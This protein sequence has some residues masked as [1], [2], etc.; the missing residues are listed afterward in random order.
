MSPEINEMIA[1][2]MKLQNPMPEAIK[3]MRE[4]AKSSR[5]MRDKWNPIYSTSMRDPRNAVAVLQRKRL[6]Y[7]TTRNQ[8]AGD[9]LLAQVDWATSHLLPTVAEQ[10]QVLNRLSDLYGLNELFTGKAF[11]HAA[12]KNDTAACMWGICPSYI[13]TY[14]LQPNVAFDFLRTS[15]SNQNSL[16]LLLLVVLLIVNR[17]AAFL[18]LSLG[19]PHKHLGGIMTAMCN[20]DGTFVIPDT[21]GC[22]TKG[23]LESTAKLLVPTLEPGSV[24][25]FDKTGR[26]IKI[27]PV[28]AKWSGSSS[29]SV[30]LIAAKFPYFIRYLVETDGVT[31]QM[32]VVCTDTHDIYNPLINLSDLHGT[33]KEV[34]VFDINLELNRRT[35]DLAKQL[36]FD[37][38]TVALLDITGK[39]VATLKAGERYPSNMVFSVYPPQYRPP[40]SDIIYVI[41]RDPVKLN[42]TYE[43]ATGTERMVSTSYTGVSATNNNTFAKWYFNRFKMIVLS[44]PQ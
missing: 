15:S 3:S 7:S 19:S 6:P 4:L 1:T 34:E 44:T 16:V 27:M 24:A 12:M 18:V 28:N 17:R 40:L 20:P 43:D 39:R 41:A 37:P 26:V 38:G 32:E 9:P 11:K 21:S 35:A 36:V 42:F 8:Y 13:L 5:S 31:K 14:L 2:Q 10:T 29:D 25:L 23:T 33:V 30:S 22:V